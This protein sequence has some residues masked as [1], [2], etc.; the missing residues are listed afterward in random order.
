MNFG[1]LKSKIETCLSESY[2]TNTLKDNLFVFNEMVLKNKNISKVFFLYDELSKSKG[3]SESVANEFI[4]E[5]ITAYENTIKKISTKEIKELKAWVGH[6]TC[7]NQ[8]KNIDNLFSKNLLVM[9]DKIKSKKLI[10]ESLKQTEKESKE[11]INV[12]LKAMVNVANKTIKNFVSSLSES[13]QKELN[14]IL[15]TPKETLVENYNKVKGEV[16][17][18]LSNTK[19]TESDDETVNTIDKVLGRL[20]T[21][22]FNELNYYKL[23]KL[24]ESL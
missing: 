23:I 3:L 1:E 13:E 5:S 8:Y 20:Q 24:S 14:K 9:E 18:K 10:S 12:P 17:E 4:S 15:S 16:T 2:K 11:I 21:E 19:L 7:E 22:S 6:I